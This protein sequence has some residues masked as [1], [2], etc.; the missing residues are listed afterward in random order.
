MFLSL[1]LPTKTNR[2][3]VCALLALSAG[4]LVLSNAAVFYGHAM[5]VGGAWRGDTNKRLRGRLGR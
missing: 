5:L 4:A 2:R 3:Q 1:L